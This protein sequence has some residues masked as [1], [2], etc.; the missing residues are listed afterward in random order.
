MIET[1]RQIADTTFTLPAYLENLT[2]LNSEKIFSRDVRQYPVLTYDQTTLA[3][4][5]W[6]E[7]KPTELASKDSQVQAEERK[8]TVELVAANSEFN[9]L[10]APQDQ[11]RFRNLFMASTSMADVIFYGNIRLLS[12]IA[13]KK[14]GLTYMDRVQEGSVGLQIAVEEFDYKKGF[15]FSTLANLVIEQRIRLAMYKNAGDLTGLPRK[16]Y[17]A[18][19]EARRLREE[20]YS[21]GVGEISAKEIVPRLMELGY[22][23]DE[24]EIGF[25]LSQG[26]GEISLNAPLKNED[27][28]TNIS[29]AD[30]LPDENTN[31]ERDGM[32][33]AER[34][35]LFSALEN[36]TERQARVLVQSFGL[37]GEPVKK[38]TEVAVELGVTGERVRQ[39]QKAAIEKLRDILVKKPTSHEE[40]VIWE[41]PEDFTE[42]VSKI[43]PLKYIDLVL[44]F[45][46][47]QTGRSVQDFQGKDKDAKLVEDRGIA[48]SLIHLHPE[49]ILRKIGQALGGRDH[50]TIINQ[51][52]KIAD[53]RKTNPT[54]NNFFEKLKRDL[55]NQVKAIVSAS[56]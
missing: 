54:F 30:L 34:E 2:E 48:S 15:R 35:E 50:S 53:K 28:E 23:E 42:T 52:E 9:A 31:T 47:S 17:K 41:N 25:L 16:V 6:E 40:Q 55:H 43:P 20:L 22:K 32:A 1:D 29:L 21:K 12:T 45:V 26:Y 49:V 36:L 24:A 44:N 7:R 27:G 33:A 5:I 8:R 38:L 14:R 10:I 46:A 19:G 18:S 11:E 39:I 3:Y 37:Y 4:K 51:L 56:S 13:S